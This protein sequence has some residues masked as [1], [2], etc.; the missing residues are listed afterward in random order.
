LLFLAASA[1]GCEDPETAQKAY[2]QRK[3]RPSFFAAKDPL[4]ALRLRLMREGGSLFGDKGRMQDKGYS[5]PSRLRDEIIDGGTASVP[6]LIKLLS[7]QTATNQK[8]GCYWYG[9]R[10]SA[11]ALAAL[12]DLFLDASWQHS[13]MPVEPVTGADKNDAAWTAFEKVIEANGPNVYRK[14]WEAAWAKYGGRAYWD[15]G[16]QCFKLRS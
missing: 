2:E 11:L 1:K 12:G 5:P 10:V 14:V 15:S 8:I 7:D 6:L 4:R 3:G 9:A 13:T 16:E